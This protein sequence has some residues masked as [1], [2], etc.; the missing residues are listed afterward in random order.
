MSSLNL[1]SLTNRFDY[2]LKNSDKISKRINKRRNVLNEAMEQTDAGYKTEINGHE[3][4]ILYADEHRVT[5]LIDNEQFDLEVYDRE[6]YNDGYEYDDPMDMTLYT[7]DF[8]YNDGGY[9]AAV[10]VSAWGND[11]IGYDIS[12]V[13]QVEFLKVDDFGGI[14]GDADYDEMFN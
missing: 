5:L 4:V 6:I 9:V 2:F 8:E 13:Y 12:D 3:I 11:N 14:I 1:H 10:S 7:E